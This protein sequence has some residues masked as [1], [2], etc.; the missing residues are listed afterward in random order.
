MAPCGWYRP[1]LIWAVM[2]GETESMVD[3]CLSNP[4]VGWLLA[5]HT[6]GYRPI[7]FVWWQHGGRIIIAVDWLQWSSRYIILQKKMTKSQTVP[8][9]W[10]WHRK[11]LSASCVHVCTLVR[12][13]TKFKAWNKLKDSKR[14]RERSPFHKHTVPLWPF[15]CPPKGPFTLLHHYMPFIKACD[16]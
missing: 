1:S 14:K 16:L 3:W 2:L 11:Q 8:H 4:L 13:I 6:A 15:L 5:S 9:D 10:H 12:W 7:V